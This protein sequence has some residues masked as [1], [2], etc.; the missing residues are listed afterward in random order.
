MEICTQEVYWGVLSG[1]PGR[2]REAEWADEAV[3]NGAVTTEV[4]VDVTGG[5]V[6]VPN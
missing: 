1:T 2:K 3:N 5:A 6:A 4:S